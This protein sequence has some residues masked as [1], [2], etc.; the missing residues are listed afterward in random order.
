MSGTRLGGMVRS[1]IVWLRNRSFLLASLS[2][3]R[4]SQRR[5]RA[6]AAS[7]RER[8]GDFEFP[9]LALEDWNH[10]ADSRILAFKA[11]LDRPRP[12]YPRLARGFD[13]GSLRAP[14]VL[15]SFHFGVGTAMQALFARLPA[16]V[17]VIDRAP[18]TAGD[19]VRHVWRQ[20]DPMAPIEPGRGELDR[21]RAVK[22]AVDALRAGQFVA[23]AVDLVG[24]ACVPA[25]LFGE[26]ITLRGG[27]FA[28]SRL[29]NAPMLPVTAQWRGARVQ[30][31][32]GQ[33]IPPDEDQVMA[34]ALTRWLE[35]YLRENP[36]YVTRTIFHLARL[37]R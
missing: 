22:E 35:G 17:L 30:I 24:T 21:I 10:G 28:F 36:R 1:A 23:V 3:W 14:M 11:R 12:T 25:T 32:H 4:S 5:L 29:A 6:F 16:Q 33:L 8:I 18:P 37:G 15:A 9:I 34:A 20:R 13:P 19:R 7:P 2:D 26:P 27:G 31:L